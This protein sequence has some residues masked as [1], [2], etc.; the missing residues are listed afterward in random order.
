[1]HFVSKSTQNVISE[2]LTGQ[3]QTETKFKNTP[4]IIYAVFDCCLEIDKVVDKYKGIAANPRIS[5]RFSE[6]N[7]CEAAPRLQSI[8]Y[9]TRNYIVC[10]HKGTYYLITRDQLITIHNKIL[11]IYNVLHISYF[12]TDVNLSKDFFIRCV[13]ILRFMSVHV[14]DKGNESYE[15]F[16]SFDG[17]SAALVLKYK[18]VFA[19]DD[20]LTFLR[21]SPLESRI[22]TPGQWEF[23][24][25]QFGD[26]TPET[27]EFSGLS[28]LLGH[29]DIDTVSGLIK[30]RQ[31]TMVPNYVSREKVNELLCFMKENFCR[32]YLRRHSRWP[33]VT[34]HFLSNRR[35]D[36]CML[37]NK[38]IDDP[39]CP[40][41]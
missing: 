10:K 39:S 41:H 3:D 8:F 30:L 27:M 28:K 40:A 4:S 9:F 16:K 19:N 11:E 21:E 14:T 12:L 5:K 29:P 34:L 13:K 6:E 26:G 32:Q 37:K 31:R 18:D 15:L 25:T 1:M 2:I 33:P 24:I 17:I 20:P 38:W 23:L 22:C 35:L 36:W 7:Y